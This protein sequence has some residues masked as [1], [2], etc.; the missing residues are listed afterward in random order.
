MQLRTRFNRRYR[1]PL[2]RRRRRG[3]TLAAFA[4]AAAA[5]N[6]CAKATDGESEGR[7]HLEKM[8]L[9]RCEKDVG[10]DVGGGAACDDE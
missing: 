10:D 5:M 3:S 2:L 6:V 7:G 1:Q 9:K 8:E 4:C